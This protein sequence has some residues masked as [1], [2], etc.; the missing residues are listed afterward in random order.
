MDRG[1]K[2]L[3]FIGGVFRVQTWSAI[4]AAKD[5]NLIRGRVFKPWSEQGQT[6]TLNQTQHQIMLYPR[7][8]K[9]TILFAIPAAW[10]QTEF[11]RHESS[12]PLACFLESKEQH[13]ARRDA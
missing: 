11:V 4:F 8:A 12:R 1:W 5:P 3:N 9:G 13:D 7:A 6:R 10:S 2:T